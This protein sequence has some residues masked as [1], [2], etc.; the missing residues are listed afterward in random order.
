MMG[1]AVALLERQGIWP[2]IMRE[3]DLRQLYIRGKSPEDAAG[4]AETAYWNTR[5]PF[6]RMRKR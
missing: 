6:E 2:G 4:Q 3:R 5:P 1:R